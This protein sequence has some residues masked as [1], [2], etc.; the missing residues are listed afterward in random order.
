[1]IGPTPTFYDPNAL[2]HQQRSDS[3]HYERW[4]ASLNSQQHQ[5]SSRQEVGN[6][7]QLT[8]QQIYA[9]PLQSQF[10][11]VQHPYTVPQYENSGTGT[12]SRSSFGATNA[13]NDATSF[14]Q[15]P[16]RSAYTGHY[17]RPGTGP[18][19]PEGSLPYSTTPDSIYSDSNFQYLQHQQ[20]HPRYP[21]SSTA[22]SFPDQSSAP[23]PS[24][25]QLA[26]SSLSAAST[27]WANEVYSSSA[28]PNVNVNPTTTQST[29]SGAFDANLGASTSKQQHSAPQPQPQPVKD[30]DKG[31][32]SKKGKPQSTTRSQSQKRPSPKV[33][34][35]GETEKIAVKRKRPRKGDKDAEQQPYHFDGGSDSDDEDDEDDADVAEGGISVG[36]GG[37]G[38]VT[39]GGKVGRS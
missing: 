19:T 13:L 28:R 15:V 10:T 14:L 11:T 18:H 30:K 17:S 21:T 5:A 33:Q 3:A 31:K 12:V 8:E 16:S 22:T 26:T 32:K 24:N 38:V 6:T 27:A 20:P 23:G 34:Q 39:S 1:M 4:I 29:L 25:P 9:P 36:M 37:L 2:M 35:K 7:A